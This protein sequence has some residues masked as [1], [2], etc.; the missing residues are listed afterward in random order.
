MIKQPSMGPIYSLEISKL[1]SKIEKKNKN[2]GFR[3][4]SF[5]IHNHQINPSIKPIKSVLS[6][7]NV[8]DSKSKE[9]RAVFSDR[10]HKKNIYKSKFAIFKQKDSTDVLKQEEKIII[11]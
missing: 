7:R 9:F 1:N 8:M 10:T 4:N 6:F 11:I 2:D 5:R 3:L